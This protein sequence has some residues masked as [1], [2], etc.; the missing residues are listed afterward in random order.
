MTIEEIHNAIGRVT[1]NVIRLGE[2][3]AQADNLHAVAL[4]GN[5]LSPVH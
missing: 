5:K 2:I 1:P 4:S 3:L